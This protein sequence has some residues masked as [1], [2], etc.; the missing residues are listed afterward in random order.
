M[1]LELSQMTIWIFIELQKYTAKLSYLRK[2]NMQS[3]IDT[4]IATKLWEESWGRRSGSTILESISPQTSNSAYWKTGDPLCM[5]NWSEYPLSK[6]N[7]IIIV[8][9]L[10]HDCYALG[11]SS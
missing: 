8:F 1:R 7:I 10:Y 5:A 2:R 3:W 4:S 6:I 11:K 9:F